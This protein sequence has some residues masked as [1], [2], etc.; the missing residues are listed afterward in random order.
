VNFAFCSRDS[1]V[2]L[3]DPRAKLL[4]V[5]TCFISVI[6]VENPI[7]YILLLFIFILPFFFSKLP[8]K[9]IL[10]GF[11]PFWILFLLTF[12]LHLFLTPGKILFRLG[13]LNATLEGSLKGFLYTI[14]IVFLVLGAMFFG[15][16]TSPID[17]ADSL[18]GFFSRF[19]SETLR[20]I[21]MI[22]IFVFRFIPFMFKEGKR[23][24]MAYKARCGYIKMGKDLFSLF[25]I[26]VHSSI[27]RADQLTLGLHAKAYQV[28]E[29]RTTIN[30]F[31]FSQKDFLF[32]AYSI[33]P[34]IIV[35]FIR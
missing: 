5:F 23:A 31:R 32:M 30:E 24:M 22:M 13:V 7:A 2:H 18:S 12:L 8:P 21:P 17:L 3:L 35:I 27:R 15:F 6:F 11:S 10:K 28:G 34:I 1:L 19:K 16:T 14:R 26:I 33:I 29:K 25:F 20:E 4:F 9:K